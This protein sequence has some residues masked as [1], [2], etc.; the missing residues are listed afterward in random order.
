VIVERSG[1]Q[2]GKYNLTAF[3]AL[4]GRGKLLRTIDGDAGLKMPPND[5]SPDG[6]TFAVGRN[7]GNE[8]RIQLLSLTGGSDR[9]IAVKGWT[10]LSAIDWAADSLRRSYGRWPTWI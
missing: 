1:T 9:E 2:K 5:L 6:A 3:D 8:T 4:N 7:G 10:N